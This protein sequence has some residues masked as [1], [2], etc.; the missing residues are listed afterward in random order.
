MKAVSA[1]DVLSAD[2]RVRSARNRVYVVFTAAGF[3]FAS[4]AARIPQVRSQLRV[5]PGVL[6]LILLSIAIGS[7][8]AMPLSGLVITRIGN[9]ARCW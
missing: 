8:I 2:V 4:W 3:A 9:A 1:T 7:T 6:G 5:S